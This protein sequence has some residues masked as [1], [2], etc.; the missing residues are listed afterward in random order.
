MST[1]SNKSESEVDKQVIYLS[2]GFYLFPLLKF[3]CNTNVTRILGHFLVNL[4]KHSYSFYCQIWRPNNGAK[5]TINLVQQIELDF[6]AE[7]AKC[8]NTSH[9]HHVNCFINYTLPVKIEVE[10]HDFLGFYTSDN[11]LA[12]PLFNETKSKTQLVMLSSRTNQDIINGRSEYMN[13]SYPQIIGNDSIN[14]TMHVCK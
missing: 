2:Y 14:Y 9:M 4:E 7:Y 8:Q 12:R 1:F 5:D 13:S 10:G 11:S 6:N 3:H